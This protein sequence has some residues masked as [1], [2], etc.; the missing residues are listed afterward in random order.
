VSLTSMKFGS[1]I[2]FPTLPPCFFKGI[3][4]F[5]LG[6]SV[7]EFDLWDLR[8]DSPPIQTIKEIINQV[9]AA[10]DQLNVQIR[11]RDHRWEPNE[12]D[13]R[14]LSQAM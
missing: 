3:V 8:R 4:L 12:L 11:F 14:R 10:I 5:L 1:D 13:S 6:G 9:A 2:L 7:E